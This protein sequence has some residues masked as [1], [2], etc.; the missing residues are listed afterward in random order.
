MASRPS[1][2]LSARTAKP[3]IDTVKRL[4][5]LV[6]LATISPACLRA[7]EESKTWPA[8][9]KAKQFVK[10]SIVIGFFASPYG[11]GWLEEK[12]VHDYLDRSRA[13]GITG[14]DMT[15]AAATFTWE[16][17]LEEL[18]RYRKA[19]A[20]QPGKYIYV[21]STRDIQAA[22]EEGKTA[23]LWNTQTSTILNNDLKK[24]PILKEQGITSMI[25]TYNDVFRAG[26]GGLAEYN[27]TV[28]GLTAWGRAI[29]DELVK[30]G[31]MV[32]LSHTGP[33]TCMDIIEYMEEEHPGVPFSYTHSLPAGLYK[34][35]P[36][37]TERGCYRNISDEEARR[38]AK[39]GGFVSPTFTEWMMDG[40]WP[41]DITPEQ[42]ADMI[43]YYVK[44][45]GAD[46][47]GIASDDM[48]TY[49]PTL[50]FV[51]RNAAAYDDGGYMTKAFERGAVGCGEL[52]KILAAV[53]D[54]LWE[55]GY[56]NEDLRKIYG[57][58]KMRV[59]AKI[60]GETAPEVKAAGE[61]DRQGALRALKGRID[62]E[63]DPY[64]PLGAAAI[65]SGRNSKPAA[66]KP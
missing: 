47:V 61:A 40:I 28:I 51:A 14:H 52:A 44:L 43:D 64:D 65:H 8:S 27:G 60:W 26:S 37:A 38:A 15:L 33:K 56:N 39:S 29:I 16:Q 23:V 31:I 1:R 59:Y 32:D 7:G 49:K 25:L 12:T 20:G 48:F 11:A 19:F 30:Y 50:D 2:P 34:D 57:L 55:R 6:A 17:Y 35:A 42:C 13:A 24:V 21:R 4:A 54:E 66:T 3:S 62:R 18:A 45:V 36:E 63:T 41:D 22:H 58:N 53:T 5:A 9:D 10:D 46:H